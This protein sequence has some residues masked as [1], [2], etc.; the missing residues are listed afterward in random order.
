MYVL[1]AAA[2]HPNLSALLGIGEGMALTKNV[3]T[4][5]LF[6]YSDLFKVLFFFFTMENHHQPTIWSMYST[7]FRMKP[8]LPSFDARSSFLILFRGELLS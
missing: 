2:G 3:E 4:L 6:S 5:M 7:T 1:Q 8:W